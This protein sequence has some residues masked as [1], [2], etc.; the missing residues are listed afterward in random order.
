MSIEYSTDTMNLNHPRNIWT[1][2]IQLIYTQLAMIPLFYY[3]REVVQL[4]VDSLYVMLF[5]PVSV[6]LL[7]FIMQLLL[8]EY[9]WYSEKIYKK[10]DI[11]I[12]ASKS[13][14]YVIGVFYILYLLMFG[15]WF[16]ESEV[17]AD[18]TRIENNV[19]KTVA[20]AGVSIIIIL[21]LVMLR[22]EI[23]NQK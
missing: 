17:Y 9:Y 14:T 13:A 6:G 10:R 4:E 18:I 1:I 22:R 19:G 7:L 15:Y 11:V 3:L 23:Q 12:V 20:E 8:N 2:S 5:L 16:S 21:F